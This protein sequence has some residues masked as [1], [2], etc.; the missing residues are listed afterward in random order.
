MYGLIGEKL[1]HSFSPEIHK[2]LGNYEYKLFELSENELPNF[3]FSGKFKGLNVTIPYKKAVIPHL[4]AMSESARKIGSVNTITVLPTGGLYGDNTDYD[5][6]SYMLQKSGISVQNKKVLV[7]GS[8]GA[9]LT[10]IAVLNDCGAGEI[11]NISRT[12]ENNYE[13]LENHFDADV[14]VNTTPVGMYPNNLKAPLSLEG[15]SHLSGVLDIIYNPA[16]TAL[17]LEAEKMGIPAMGGLS[18]LVAQAKRASEI[19][20]GKKIPDSRIDEICQK[21]SN[22]MLNI[23]LIGMPG[24]GKTT[25]GSCLAEK[26]GRE[27]LDTDEMVM[28]AEGSTIPQIFE[29]HGEAYFRR[30]EQV[31][32]SVAGKES[33]KIIATGGG[34]AAN[35]KNFDALRQNSRIVFLN[36]E[37]AALPTDGRPVSQ[38]TDLKELL[39]K[40]LPFYRELCDLEIDGNGSAEET[41]ENIIKELGL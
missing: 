11:V 24:C 6:F 19:F 3:L 7:L 32:V 1:K 22:D 20:T 30:C 12:G 37:L 31:A 15:F 41:A 9:S 39:R 34:A 36:R 4:Q 25:V 16:K 29:Q 27:L 10:V 18:M 5:G 14:I 2:L 28:R 40:R 35:R 23:V 33:G 21:L 8:G 13:N 26:L 17:V 38:S